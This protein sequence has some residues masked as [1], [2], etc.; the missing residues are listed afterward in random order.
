MHVAGLRSSLVFLLQR[1]STPPHPHPPLHTAL[2]LPETK[3]KLKKKRYLRQNLPAGLHCITTTHW[4][5][6]A[7]ACST[8]RLHGTVHTHKH[9][10]SYRR[11]CTAC[12]CAGDHPSTT[13]ST[14]E[15][16]HELARAI[17]EQAEDTDTQRPSHLR[18]QVPELN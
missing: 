17:E 7:S 18:L 15:Y 16:E 5:T 2:H 1:E 13:T 4:S 8:A 11:F 9:L 12:P 14:Y 6:V 10:Q 3:K